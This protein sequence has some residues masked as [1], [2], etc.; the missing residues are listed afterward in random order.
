MANQSL[1][2]RCQ[3]L[4]VFE[5]YFPKQVRLLFFRDFQDTEGI[6]YYTRVEIYSQ[7]EPAL[8]GETPDRW[9]KATS[10][11]LPISL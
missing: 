6:L 5:V 3:A 9:E 10:R 2:R 1:L 8:K 11:V 7:Q 4:Y